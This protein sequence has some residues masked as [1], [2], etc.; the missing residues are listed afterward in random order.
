[1]TVHL[2]HEIT[3]NANLMQ[4]GNFIDVFLARHVS[5]TYAHHQE[6]HWMLTIYYNMLSLH[7]IC[8]SC[9]ITTAY[10][11]LHVS[12]VTSPSSGQ[13]GIMLIKVHSLAF[14]IG[15]PLFTLKNFKLIR[16][17]FKVKMLLDIKLIIKYITFWSS[18]LQGWTYVLPQSVVTL[19]SDCVW[20]YMIVRTGRIVHIKYQLGFLI[21]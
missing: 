14:S 20:L 12:T 11:Q 7:N 1:M 10:I 9:T 16:F 13:Q 19:V 5:G 3:W 6:H 4:Q 21:N 2:P 18:T 17:V 15:N 8:N